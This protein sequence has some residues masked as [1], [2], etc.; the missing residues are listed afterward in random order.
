M[1]RKENT[2]ERL[3]RF[4]SGSGGSRNAEFGALQRYSRSRV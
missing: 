2:K 1:H 4:N 3:S